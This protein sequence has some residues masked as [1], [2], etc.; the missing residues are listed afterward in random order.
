MVEAECDECGCV[1]EVA[2]QAEY[3]AWLCEYCWKDR[4]RE[5][6]MRQT[7]PVD[8]SDEGWFAR[9]ARGEL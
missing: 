7:E 6:E 5:K 4:E 3:S 2:Y 1:A 8:F 9:Y